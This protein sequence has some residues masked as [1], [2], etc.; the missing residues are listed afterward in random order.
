MRLKD[1]A[2]AMVIGLQKGIS[3]T[4][5]PFQ[6]RRVGCWILILLLLRVEEKVC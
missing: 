1:E 5:Q 4:F 6:L 2:I 3:V